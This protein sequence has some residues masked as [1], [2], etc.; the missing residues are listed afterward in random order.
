VIVWLWDADGPARAARGITDD[1]GAARHAAEACLR[2]GQA[3][4]AAVE[5]ARA[6]LGTESLT[7]GY[8][9]TGNGWTGER[10]QDGQIS[11]TPLAGSPELAA[12]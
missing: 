3:R 9:R 6:V 7:S 5:Q 11:W 2:S 1:V 8:Q 10:R 12:S 4:C